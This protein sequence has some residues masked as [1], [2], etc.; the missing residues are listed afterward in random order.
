M[1]TER[2]LQSTGQPGKACASKTHHCVRHVI[3]LSQVVTQVALVRSLSGGM[4]D[5]AGVHARRNLPGQDLARFNWAVAGGA[6]LPGFQVV[7]MTEEN[8]IRDSVD[9][10]PFYPLAPSVKLRQLLELGMG[11]TVGKVAQNALFDVRNAGLIFIV[12][13]DMAGPAGETR[14]GV[15]LMAESDGLRAHLYGEFLSFSLVDRR[16]LAKRSRYRQAKKQNTP[17]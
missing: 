15:L 5:Y 16:L 14:R 11:R 3:L 7:D 13:I 4:T 9:A 17:H 1:V 8:E 2:Q 12:C 6:L 10:H